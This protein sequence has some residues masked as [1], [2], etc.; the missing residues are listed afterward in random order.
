LGRQ[1]VDAAVAHDRRRAHRVD[2][3]LDDGAD[4][5]SRA[6]PLGRHHA[7]PPGGAGE[8]VQVRAFGV[9]EAQGPRQRVQDAVGDTGGVASLQ[10][11]VVLDAHAGERRDLLAAQALDPSRSVARETD[12]LRRDLRPA[13]GEEL[14]DVLGGVHVIHRAPT[15]TAQR[16]PASTPSR[17]VPQEVRVR[18]TVKVMRAAIFHEPHRV[19]AGDRSDAALLREPADAVCGHEGSA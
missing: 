3:A 18:A 15:R 14:G 17:R 1:I 6:A 4:A 9:V 10:A 16:C 7:H 13:R 8:V 19:E 11:L 5:L 2:D 12:L